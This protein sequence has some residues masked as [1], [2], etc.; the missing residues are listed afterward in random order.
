M[1]TASKSVT[2]I[3]GERDVKSRDRGSKDNA[4]TTDKDSSVGCDSLFQCARFEHFGK[5]YKRHQFELRQLVFL[6]SASMTFEFK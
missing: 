6:R 4:R 2:K 3:K 1:D 5:A